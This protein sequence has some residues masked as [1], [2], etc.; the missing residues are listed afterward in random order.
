MMETLLEATQRLRRDGLVVDSTSEG[1][2]QR[3]CRVEDFAVPFG[4]LVGSMF[5][6]AARDLLGVSH[7]V[8]SSA[9]E[10]QR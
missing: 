6:G 4:E 5:F 7:D 2:W 1:D 9:R 8:R 10:I 3:T